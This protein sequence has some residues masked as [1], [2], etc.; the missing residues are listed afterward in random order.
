VRNNRVTRKIT[1]NYEHPLSRQGLD[2]AASFRVG[3]EI[4]V[5]EVGFEGPERILRTHDIKAARAH[6]SSLV[7]RLE[8]HGFT[9]RSER[10]V[11]QEGRR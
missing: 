4:V 8:R 6:W 1:H 3:G 9:K 7:A 10:D 11:A 5:R 2:V